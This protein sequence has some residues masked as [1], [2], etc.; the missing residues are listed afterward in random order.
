MRSAQGASIRVE[1]F[2]SFNRAT[3]GNSPRKHLSVTRVM[4]TIFSGLASFA[5]RAAP[6]ARA[7]AL[8]SGLALFAGCSSEPDSHVV[9]APPPLAPSSVVS[10]PVTVTTQSTTTGPVTTTQTQPVNTIVVTQAPPALQSEVVLAR[11][12]PDYVW[13]AG[14]WTWRDNRY[15]WMAGQ[16]VIPPHSNSAWVAPHWEPENGG[17]RFYEGYWN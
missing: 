1:M 12:S 9:S 5:T 6:R 3:V 7:F 15:E 11:P 10:Q 14:Y 17:Y 2:G 13:V 8:L 16:W 4:N